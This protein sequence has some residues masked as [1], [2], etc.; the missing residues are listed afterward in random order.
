M[1][2]ILFVVP[3]PSKIYP[4]ERFRVEIYETV[5]KEAGFEF[6]TVFFWD[7]YARSILYKKGKILQ[8]T[9]CG[10]NGILR[11]IQ[12]LFILNRFDYVFVLR[13]A[14]PVGPPF[15]EWIYSKIFRKKFIYDFDDAIW[16]PQVSENNSW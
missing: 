16:I 4:S 8:K 5:L 9:F 6:E 11:R 13:E 7:Y 1:K 15:F 2:K 12:S 14:A 3:F 10:I